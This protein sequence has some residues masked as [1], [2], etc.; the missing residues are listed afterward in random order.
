MPGA[1]YGW[2]ARIGFIG[3]SPA[4]ENG[5]Y[6]FYRMVPPGVT[7]VE[8]RLG[9]TFTG[10]ADPEV[11][12]AGLEEAVRELHVRGV[13]AIIQVGVPY[14]VAGGPGYERTVLERVAKVTSIPA[15][16]D[17]FTCVEA[18][19]ALSV[20]RVALV[21]PFPANTN[22]DIGRYLA[23]NDITVR[24]VVRATQPEG[25]DLSLMPLPEIYRS[26]KRAF[27]SAGDARGV[28][29][30][31]ARMPSVEIIA[32]LEQD[33]GVPVVSSMQAMTWTGL[34]L[35]GVRASIDGYG[36]LFHVAD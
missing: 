12:F 3:P 17:I 14:V 24:S 26:A 21:T 16:C 13:D 1:T 7:L 2:R 28:L 5:P 8:T 20:E 22:D 4:T 33:L 9:V 23:G 32:E 36:R 34:R 10:R 35:A 19:R 27:A 31:G 30:N 25:V 15:S 18:L 6:E 11:A 29:I